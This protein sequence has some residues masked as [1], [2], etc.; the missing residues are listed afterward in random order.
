MTP[1]WEWNSHFPLLLASDDAF[2]MG[3]LWGQMSA[4]R[5]NQDGIQE[6]TQRMR[7]KREETKAT[8]LS[9]TWGLCFWS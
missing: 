3:G 8:G 2:H 4:G 7:I 1:G 5:A 6:A 9:P